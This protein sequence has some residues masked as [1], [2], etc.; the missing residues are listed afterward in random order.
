MTTPQDQ[1]AIDAATIADE[2]MSNPPLPGE[3]D[4]CV[5]AILGLT[6]IPDGVSW[7][8]SVEDCFRDLSRWSAAHGFYPSL[9]FEGGDLCVFW[10]AKGGDQLG[11]GNAPFGILANVLSRTFIAVVRCHAWRTLI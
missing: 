11:G 9:E 1:A 10:K 3:V 4:R 8:A 5:A 7:E 6:E 2:T